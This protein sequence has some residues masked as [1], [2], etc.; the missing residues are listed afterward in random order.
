MR[1][2]NRS[3]RRDDIKAASLL[4]PVPF[5]AAPLAG[6]SDSSG[7]SG[8][9]DDGPRYGNF[10]ASFGDFVIVAFIPVLAVFAAFPR[11]FI[12]GL[13]SGGVKS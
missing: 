11:W 7:D 1:R 13:T 12:A 3:Q 2:C 5:P 6:F 8:T 10:F 4:T 9:N